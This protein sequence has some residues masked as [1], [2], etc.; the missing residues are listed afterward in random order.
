MT[1]DIGKCPQG[2]T[3]SWE[4]LIQWKMQT[5]CNQISAARGKQSNG[6]ARNKRHSDINADA[7]N[8]TMSRCYIG[9][10]ITYKLEDMSGEINHTETW[11]GKNWGVKSQRTQDLWNSIKCFN[12]CIFEI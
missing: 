11:S 8:E 4:P 9:D 6:N 10:T 5:T 2:D 12:I 1:P 3:P 7:I